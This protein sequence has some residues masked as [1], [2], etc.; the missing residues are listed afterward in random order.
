[1]RCD[2]DRWGAGLTD[3]GAGL[4]DAVHHDY[5]GSPP[6]VPL[7]P[8]AS[9]SATEERTQQLMTDA[10]EIWPGRPYP[11][12]AA[13]DGGG[14]NFSLFS[15][16]AEGVELCLFDD[17]GGE[18]RI[19]LDEVDGSCWHAYLPSV[20]PGQRYGYRVHGPWAPE[21]G[22]RCNSAKLLIDPYAK[23]IERWVQG[24]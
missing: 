17:D 4:T 15:E 7:Q 2:R 21:A 3:A 23:A 14:T 6:A 13:Y 12:G 10:I 5:C 18:Q 16:V 9:A 19:A 11:L 1:M 22:Q 20:A 8:R 24:G